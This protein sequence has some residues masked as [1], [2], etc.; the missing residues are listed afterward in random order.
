MHSRNVNNKYCIVITALEQ[1]LQPVDYALMTETAYYV[2][3]V[4]ALR[5]P[6]VTVG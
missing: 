4:L 3:N 1:N 6:G 5:L 2:H